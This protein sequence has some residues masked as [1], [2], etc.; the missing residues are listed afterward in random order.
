MSRTCAPRQD[1]NL[2][3][4]HS[5]QQQTSQTHNGSSVASKAEPW[6]TA[7]PG[8]DCSLW[9]VNDTLYQNW[10]LCAGDNWTFEERIWVC[11]DDEKD[12]W[13]DF[14]EDDKD[15]IISDC[16]TFTHHVFIAQGYMVSEI[17]VCYH[18][19]DGIDVI[20]SD[21]GD[22]TTMD[23]HVSRMERII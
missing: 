11:D 1:N 10:T 7:V 20:V 4:V 21:I 19:M 14:L 6:K 23:N 3:G 22:I 5:T 18:D 9:R 17:R 16:N 8:K 15:M 12:M 2:G 13:D